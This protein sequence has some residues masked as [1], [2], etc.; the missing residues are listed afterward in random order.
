[1]TNPEL[2]DL[3][4]L[5]PGKTVKLAPYDDDCMAPII[6]NGGESNFAVP[7]FST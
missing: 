4:L 2:A 3:A 1:M 6:L 5:T 7:T